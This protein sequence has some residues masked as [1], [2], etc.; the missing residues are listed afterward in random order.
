MRSHARVL[1]ISFQICEA[2]PMFLHLF[3]PSDASVLSLKMVTTLLKPNF[4]ESG[5]NRRRFENEV[6]AAFTKYLREAASKKS[7]V[8]TVYCIFQY[9]TGKF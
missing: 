1:H 6:Y 2:M 3:R 7:I 9:S 4:S 5:S 8:T